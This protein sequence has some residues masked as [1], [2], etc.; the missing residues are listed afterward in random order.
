MDQAALIALAK[1][2]GLHELARALMEFG[3]QP[4]P[5]Q[6]TQAIQPEAEPTA[7]E[8][9]A[10]SPVAQIRQR[11]PGLGTMFMEGNAEATPPIDIANLMAFLRMGFMDFAARHNR[12]DA[13]K[14]RHTQGFSQPNLR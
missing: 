12:A 3:P 6:P 4:A 8:R 1:E 10:R 9:A 13:A 2:K 5:A 7:L 11:P 14:Q